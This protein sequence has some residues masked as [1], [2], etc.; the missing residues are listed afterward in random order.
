M[1]KKL[2][3][4]LA[5]VA[6]CAAPTNKHSSLEL[7]RDQREFTSVTA[8]GGFNLGETRFFGNLDLNSPYN[9]ADTS[10]LARFN[11]RARL[12]RPVYNGFGLTSEYKAFSGDNN[13]VAG[14]GV[15]YSPI[16]GIEVRTYPL[17][18]D[19]ETKEICL[20]FGRVFEAGKL[21][22]YVRGFFDFGKSKQNYS[23]GEIQLGLKTEN[24]FR[25][26]TELRHS[27]MERRNG[28]K[29]PAASFG[30]GFDF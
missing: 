27:E 4:A 8:Q 1:F 11:G 9:R 10:D 15:S 26:F 17:K 29:S 6:G 3:L 5:L 18:T 30:L 19:G 24:G 2:C 25:V 7:I 16:K 12:V 22:P 28:I 13:D 21:D 20:S 14:F 23:V